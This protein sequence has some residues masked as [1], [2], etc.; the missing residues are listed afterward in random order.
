MILYLSLMS[1]FAFAGETDGAHVQA[2]GTKVSGSVELASSVSSNPAQAR[3]SPFTGAALYLRPAVHVSRDRPTSMLS[4]DAQY[5][6]RKYVNRQATAYDR[7][8][9]FDLATRLSTGMQLPLGFELRHRSGMQADPFGGYS[10]QSNTLHLHNDLDARAV[11]RVRTLRFYVGG[12]VDHDGYASPDGSRDLQLAPGAVAGAKWL[13]F[14]RTAI[15]LEGSWNEIAKSG[16]SGGGNGRHLRMI[17][18]VR[19]RAS[20]RTVGIL[21]AGYGVGLYG[22]K[23][24][25]ISGLSGIVVNASVKHDFSETRSFTL[26]YHKDFDTV[27][28]SNAVAYHAVEAKWSSE[29]GRGFSTDI[30]V[31]PRLQTYK[32]EVARTDVY[33]RASGVLSYKLRDSLKLQGQVNYRQRTSTGADVGFVDVGGQVGVRLAY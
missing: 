27:F 19:S 4:L 9:D 2:G 21:T 33:M 17:T 3:T 22:D 8:T 13:Y 20:E 12:V 14:P 29:H 15:V 7:F 10:G 32:G 24:G 31:D 16:S 30:I 26:G 6:L 23:A 11:I 5:G 28:F 25:N 18:G 1:M